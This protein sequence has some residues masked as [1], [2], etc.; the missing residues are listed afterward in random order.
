MSCDHGAEPAQPSSSSVGPEHVDPPVLPPELEES[1]ELLGELE[2]L[3][4]LEPLELPESPPLESPPELLGPLPACAT[5]RVVS[6][7]AA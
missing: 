3:E 6:A 7:G 2:L 4:L 1:L 5:L